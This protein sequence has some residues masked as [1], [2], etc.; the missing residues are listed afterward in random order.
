MKI[1]VW[2]NLPSGGGKRA[3]HDHVRGLVERGHQVECWSPPTADLSYLPLSQY[4]IEHVVPFDWQFVESHGFLGRKLLVFRNVVAKF[5]AMQRHAQRCVEE[6]ERG[7]FDVILGNSC[8]HF[9]TPF[10]ARFASTPTV[11]YLQEP[12]RKFY[13]ASPSGDMSRL[14][15]VAPLPSPLRKNRLLRWKT[16]AGR[17]AMDLGEL[18]AVRIQARE[19]CA[20]AHAFDRV[21][22]NSRYSRE[23]ILR[24][25][26]L[27]A[28]VCYL[29]IDTEM[30]RPSGEPK[31]GYVIGLG[32]FGPHKG[33]DTAVRALATI[34][35]A[36][37]P[38]LVWVG[39]AGGAEY[40]QSVTALAS[41]LGVNLR[42]KRRVPHDELVSLLSRASVMIYTSRLEPFG[43][44]PLEANACGT[45][46]VGIAEAGIR[47]S[48]EPGEN[49]SLVEAGDPAAL[50]SEILR[51]VQ[52]PEWALSEGVRARS[53]VV[54]RWQVG[55]AV[56]RLETHLAEPLRS[57]PEVAACQ[58][59]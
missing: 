45:V 42:I 21:L 18:H 29:G 30:F 17:L 12:F 8:L 34:D 57:R 22:C 49:G 44:A 46:V 11:L 26:G 10:I 37:R 14:Q 41:D 55:A 15:W 5:G 50:G 53:H 31:E 39:N 40:L 52:T 1:A 3:L 54:D 28:K 13:E 43:F 33:I 20:N 24:V 32:E 48:I 36:L 35:P 38:A 23:A 56:E 2:H 47:E 16:Q 58:R 6:I 25:Y 4:A 51:Y 27:D 19:E 9:A 7:D 59:G